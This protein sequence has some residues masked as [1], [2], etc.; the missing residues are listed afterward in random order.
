M[1]EFFQ[2]L[3]HWLG[4]DLSREFNLFAELFPTNKKEEA[5]KTVRLLYA[6]GN[7]MLTVIFSSWNKGL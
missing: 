4:D 2:L 1:W 3:A 5:L 7:G 6:A